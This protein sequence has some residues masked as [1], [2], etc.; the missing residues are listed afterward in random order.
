MPKIIIKTHIQ[1]TLEICF[2]L[3]TSIDL[4]SISTSHTNE[5]VIGGLTSGL[6]TLNDT[7]TW[8]A[9]HFFVK[10]NLTSLIS[11][12]NRPFHFRDE[13]VKGAFKKFKHDHIF[14]QHGEEVIMTDVFD[15]E[16]PFG[17]IGKAFNTLVLTNYMRK[18][19]TKR[20]A[21]IKE[22]AETEKWKL[23]LKN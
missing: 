3:A 12:F 11:A 7:V 10:Q 2:D 1:T 19:L 23:I 9:K 16:S 20:N 5:K 4:H 21:F 8:E 17:I 18:F 22:Y 15:Y 14:E 13:Q 6:V